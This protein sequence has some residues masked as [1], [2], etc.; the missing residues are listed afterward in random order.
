MEGTSWSAD[1]KRGNRSGAA[2]TIHNANSLPGIN[3]F[4]KN[5]LHAEPI[6]SSKSGIRPDR[7]FISAIKKNAGTGRLSLRRKK[8]Y[9]SD[10]NKRIL[11]PARLSEACRRL[12]G[13]SALSGIE[14]K[15]WPGNLITSMTRHHDTLPPG[16]TS[17]MNDY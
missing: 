16:L 13:I 6:S 8:P 11:L 1:P 3:R 7:Y 10:Q 17:W 2:A 15:V 12:P 4:L 14:R 5:A 9:Q